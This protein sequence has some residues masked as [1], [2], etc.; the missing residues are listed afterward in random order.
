VAG[1]FVGYGLE[2]IVSSLLRR[3][4]TAEQ[5]R[6]WL[7]VYRFSL[8]VSGPA[9]LLLIVTGGYLA[10]KISGGMG[11]PWISATLV[12]IVIALGIGFSLILPRIRAIRNSLPEGAGALTPTATANLQNAMLPTLVRVRAMLALGIV[13]LMT[14]KPMTVAGAFGGLIIAMAIGV[15]FSL[16]TFTRPKAQ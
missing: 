2:W 14:V 6:A 12:G 5:A 16:P 15:V 11:A 9:L 13:Y 10:S 3:A 8:P 4:I 1:L 7:R